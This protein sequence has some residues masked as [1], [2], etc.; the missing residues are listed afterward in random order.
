MFCFHNSSVFCSTCIISYADAIG[1]IPETIPMIRRYLKNNYQ[2]I[3]IP[4]FSIVCGNCVHDP[5]KSV[6]IISLLIHVRWSTCWRLFH[7]QL[8]CSELFARYVCLFV[9]DELI[10]SYWF[11]YNFPLTF[12]W[13][14]VLNFKGV[15]DL[16]FY[17]FCS[18]FSLWKYVLCLFKIQVDR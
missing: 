1:W 17:V 8:R 11:T 3:Y 5:F 16:L 2:L 12:L 6:T 10:I 7:H 18:H 14:F 4:V 9:F 15:T 13:M